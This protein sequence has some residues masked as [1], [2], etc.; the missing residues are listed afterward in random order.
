M[1]NE[2]LTPTDERMALTVE[3]GASILSFALSAGCLAEIGRTALSLTAS[4]PAN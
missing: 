3:V 2:H 1:A 4:S